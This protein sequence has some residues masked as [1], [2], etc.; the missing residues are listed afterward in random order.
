MNKLFAFGCSYTYGLGSTNPLLYSWPK[1]LS[2]KFDIDYENHGINGASNDHILRT[3]LETLNKFTKEDLIIIMMT[4]PDR[5][6]TSQGN[7]HYSD[8]RNKNYFMKYHSLE[9]GNLNF[10]QNYYSL[11]SILNKHNYWITFTDN[12]PLFET[13]KYFPNSNLKS[14]RNILGPDL[15]FYKSI[16]ETQHPD[17]NGYQQIAEHLYR[18]IQK[19]EIFSERQD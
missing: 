14:F 8:T 15:G 13:K 1:V 18:Y 10:I 12:R 2:Q 17:D 11:H 19:H 6:L 5:K 3:V 7:L 16:S 4:F 9:L